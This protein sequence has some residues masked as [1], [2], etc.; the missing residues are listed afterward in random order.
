M[1]TV[2]QGWLGSAFAAD[3]TRPFLQWLTAR[4]AEQ[5][6]LTE[7]RILGKDRRVFHAIIGPDEV[8]AL[9]LD[10]AP[11]SGDG[12][13]PRVGEAHI[14]FGMNPVGGEW[15][16]RRLHR[17]KRCVKDREVHAYSMLAIDID[18]V[19]PAGEAATRDEWEAA[20]DVGSAIATWLKREGCTPI[21]ADTGNG[22]HLLVPLVP[23]YGD[24]IPEASQQAQRLLKQLDQRFSTEKAKVDLCTFNP[25]R[26]LKLYGTPSLKGSG[27]PPRPHRCSRVFLKDIPEDVDL[28]ARLAAEDDAMVPLNWGAWRAEALTALPLGEV[29]GPWLTGRQSGNG[30]LECRDPRAKDANP[31]AGVADGTGPAEIGRFHSFRDGLTLSVFDFLQQVGRV[32]TLGEAC[33]LVADLS[34]VPLPE[35]AQKAVP[36]ELDAVRVRLRSAIDLPA[37]EQHARLEELVSETR[38]PRK[39]LVRTIAEEKRRRRKIRPPK[40][41]KAVVD[42][43]QNADRLEDFFDKLINAVLP[44]NRLFAQGEAACFIQSGAGPVLVNERNLS[45]LLSSLVELRV[46]QETDDGQRMLRYDR[47]SRDLARAMVHAPAVREQLPTLTRYTRSPVFT[48]DWR[49]LGTPGFDDESGVY[50]DGPAVKPRE[51]TATL[52]RLLAGFAW[53]DETDRSNFIGALLTALTM[54]HWG[55]GH[56]FLAINGNKPGVGKSTLARFLGVI[57][58]GRTPSTVSWIKDDTEFEKQ[59]A[60]RVE[61]GDRVLVVDN[62]KTSGVLSSAVLERCITDTRLSFRRLGSNTA[63]TRSENDLLF[64]LTMN[65]TSLGADLR[66]RALPVNLHIDGDV[67]SHRFASED[68]I[69]EVVRHRHAAVAELAGMVLRWVEDGSPLGAAT[70]ST[71]RLWAATI[72]GIL[73]VSGIEG[74]L[75]NFASSE[76]AFDPKYAMLA[77]MAR[78]FVGEPP[79]SASGWASKVEPWL[80]ERF[81][82]RGGVPKS[83][84][85]RSTIVGRLFGE[86]LGVEL[87]AGVKLDR[88]YPDGQTHSPT[89]AFTCS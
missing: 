56:P 17:V 53:K 74:F 18:P 67:R 13:H 42:F 30:W 31:S 29:Y 28:F 72:D 36:T 49:Y 46:M 19:R 58:E 86:Y 33:R 21:W 44:A 51:G 63:I 76:H 55:N 39:V 47:V 43:V 15:T 62:A 54:P 59:L 73:R 5:G 66:R 69:A 34:G 3:S 79:M 2:P 10:I 24:M 77:E 85:A 61:L 32:S 57:A 11:G 4:H 80:A 64:V 40:T 9:M 12:S 1:N 50:Y 70:H 7:I 20:R 82:G 65:L 22:V 81:V 78:E 38:I 23:A 35:T 6:G 27:A 75:M 68:V 41:D 16:R 48:A 71:G 26:I 14:Y 87:G 89:Y 88:A 8:E 83:D 25:S 45:G 84:R 37:L 52:D 60:T